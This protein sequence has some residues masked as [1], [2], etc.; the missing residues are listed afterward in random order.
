M[1]LH[2]ITFTI[3][4][5]LLLLQCSS[6]KTPEAGSIKWLH[7]LDSAL[8]ASEQTNKPIMIDFMAEWCPPCKAMEDSTFNRPAVITK[9]GK[10]ITL[11]ID[12][13]KQPE[14]AIEYNGNARKYGGVGI[15]N[16]LF[17]TPEKEK[18][19]HVI[20]YHNPEQLIAVMDSALLLYSQMQ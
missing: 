16:L 14:I 11:R 19:K 7:S 5:S 12:V 4:T 2:C 10:F 6:S 9:A 15:P 8:V 13:D 20:G 1:K 18:I 17:L 3:I